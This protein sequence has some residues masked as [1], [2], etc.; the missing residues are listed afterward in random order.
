MGSQPSRRQ[1]LHLTPDRRAADKAGPPP[2]GEVWLAARSPTERTPTIPEQRPPSRS[3]PS[4]SS[5]L[6]ADRSGRPDAGG[7][8]HLVQAGA[9]L[10]LHTE[11]AGFIVKSYK[12]LKAEVRKQSKYNAKSMEQRVFRA[13]YLNHS[14]LVTEGKLLNPGE[15]LPEIFQNTTFA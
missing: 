1:S 9:V 3:G 6:G 15:R 11:I 10:H 13:N 12:T 4:T 5:I 7:A 8:S 2:I 14:T